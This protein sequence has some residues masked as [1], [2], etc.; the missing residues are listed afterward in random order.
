MEFV[1]KQVTQSSTHTVRNQT[2]HDS[3]VQFYMGFKI[4]STNTLCTLAISR[5]I[6]IDYSCVDVNNSGRVL[7]IVPRMYL[8]IN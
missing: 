2:R 7:F 8:D 4:C 1:H 6:Y 5:A 3:L